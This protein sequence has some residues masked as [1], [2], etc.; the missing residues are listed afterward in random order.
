MVLQKQDRAGAVLDDSIPW[1][2]E[3]DMILSAMEAAKAS[4]PKTSLFPFESDDRRG[5]LRT[6][7]RTRAALKLYADPSDSA[8][9]TLY[10]RDADE[11]GLGFITTSLL[12]LGYAGWITLRAPSGDTV[13]V[14]CTVYRCRKAAPGWYEGALKFHREVWQLGE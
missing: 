13:H 9:R 8:A 12:P 3:V 5:T 4:A 7:Y 11:R 14:E 1:P 2:A 6:P 10:T